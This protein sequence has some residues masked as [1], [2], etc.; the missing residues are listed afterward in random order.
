MPDVNKIFGLFDDNKDNNPTPTVY[1]NFMD[2]QKG[3]LGMFVKLIQ[4]NIVFN[5]KLKQFFKKADKE[6]DEEVVRKNS[7]F[8]VFQRSWHYI[9]QV[10]ID[11]REGIE[12]IVNYEPH[13][14]KDCLNRAIKFYES[15]EEYEKC[16]HMHKILKLVEKI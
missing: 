7:Q 12:A 8:T 15:S 5:E 1:V 2:T 4:N 3:K 11:T 13:M 9:K 14:L 16:A 6:F 10:D